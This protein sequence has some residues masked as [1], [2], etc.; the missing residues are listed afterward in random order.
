VA[1]NLTELDK[2]VVAYLTGG[3]R[4]KRSPQELWDTRVRNIVGS[5]GARDYKVN[6]YGYKNQTTGVFEVVTVAPR[7]TPVS[8]PKPYIYKKQVDELDKKYT[9][10]YDSNGLIKSEYV[11]DTSARNIPNDKISGVTPIAPIMTPPTYSSNSSNTSRPTIVTTS[12]NNTST[13]NNLGDIDEVTNLPLATSKITIPN[14]TIPVL[15]KNV[16]PITKLPTRPTTSV[17]NIA[18]SSDLKLAAYN[19]LLDSGVSSNEAYHQVYG[20]GR[21]DKMAPKVDEVT[22]IQPTTSRPTSVT[23]ATM[24][25]YFNNLPTRENIKNA[26]DPAK[27]GSVT[28]MLDKMVIS[29]PSDETIIPIQPTTLPSNLY[30]AGSSNYP[31]Q[32]TPTNV[33]TIPQVDGGGKVL[34]NSD[35]AN[36]LAG[37]KKQSEGIAGQANI[38][39]IGLDVYKNSS[40]D[41]SA[42]VVPQSRSIGNVSRLRTD[43]PGGNLITSRELVNTRY[44]PGQGTNVGLTDKMVIPPRRDTNYKS[45][46]GCDINC[47]L[48]VVGNDGIT[49]P[50]VIGNAMTLSYS[51]H[52]EKFPVRVLGRSYPTG[53]TRGSRT[54]AGTIIFT[55]FDREVMWEL[56]QAYR[57]DIDAVDGTDGTVSNK[58][59]PL[60][61]QLPPFD[62]T[63]QYANEYGYSAFM[64]IY[65]VELHDEGAVMSIDDMI[66]EKTV[67]YVARDIDILRPSD[68]DAI[69]GTRQLRGS[70][71][72]SNND[73]IAFLEYL[74]T[75]RQMVDGGEGDSIYGYDI[76]YDS[77]LFATT[78][79]HYLRNKQVRMNDNVTYN[80]NRYDFAGNDIIWRGHTMSAGNS[81]G[82]MKFAPDSDYTKSTDRTYY[83]HEAWTDNYSSRDQSNISKQYLMPVGGEYVHPNY[84]VVQPEVTE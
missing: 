78:V 61:D 31:G 52:R 70:T 62:I 51:I 20:L 80:S 72:T 14:S 1:K 19:S 47:I 30:G 82:Y 54:L 23:N 5:V 73:Y 66:V 11:M 8:K 49:E 55:M 71:G 34:P 2:E 79:D 7:P 38:S 59:Y 28:N 32:N 83:I 16:S 41:R 76:P 13:V 22:T 6:P 21:L 35:L 24:V 10:M 45:F 56:L 4:T 77:A 36:T 57:M 3:T 67:Q 50:I 46:S 69:V 48:H 63:I 74:R 26:V 39:T 12:S 68:I 58:M 33:T 40:Y 60:L 27:G 29:I 17:N 42:I 37:F 75:R 84:L 65:G 18:T 81:E 64:A 9:D 44:V 43:T 53:Y 25:E 15:D